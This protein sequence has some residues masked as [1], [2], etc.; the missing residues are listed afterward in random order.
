MSP[1]YA[2]IS[3][4]QQMVN[5]ILLALSA[6]RIGASLF[7]FNWKDFELIRRHKSFSLKVLQ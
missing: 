4:T 2:M 1:Y 3:K 5:G 6:R 7:T